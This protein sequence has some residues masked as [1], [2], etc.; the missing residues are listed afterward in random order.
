MLQAAVAKP[1]VPKRSAKSTTNTKKHKQAKKAASSTTM[2]GHDDN[3]SAAFV[4]PTKTGTTPTAAGIVVDRVLLISKDPT[5]AVDSSPPTPT[6]AAP[7]VTTTTP[8]AASPKAKRTSRRLREWLPNNTEIPKT[9]TVSDL[10]DIIKAAV[11]TF[12]AGHPNEPIPQWVTQLSKGN[13]GIQIFPNSRARKGDLFA[14]NGD[15][16]SAAALSLTFS[17]IVANESGSWP[18]RGIF[19]S[20]STI[21]PTVAD[22]YT[23]GRKAARMRLGSVSF[24]LLP[25][26]A[27]G[28]GIGGSTAAAPPRNHADGVLLLVG[29][30][31]KTKTPQSGGQ[32]QN[33]ALRS[34]ASKVK[35]FLSL[36]RGA[37]P[38]HTSLALQ[39]LDLEYIGEKPAKLLRKLQ[40]KGSFGAD[41]VVVLRSKSQQ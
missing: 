28:T 2:S 38:Q 12:E 16:S 4:D 19:R 15:F 35:Y 14:K 32:M 17:V 27:G 3:S 30:R 13:G 24:F 33:G 18:N 11:T 26:G 10:D 41:S 25:T 22:V 31:S 34:A 40:A 7:A 8:A 37:L 20:L 36:V 21:T 23:R 1:R 39:T 9:R 29:Q 6:P 5:A